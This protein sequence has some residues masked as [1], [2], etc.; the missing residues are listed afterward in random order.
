MTQ[1]FLHSVHVKERRVRGNAHFINQSKEENHENKP[2][3]EQQELQ[4]VMGTPMP[5]KPKRI[6]QKPS[7]YTYEAKEEDVK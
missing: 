4:Y 3:P 6:I 5:Q 1:F 2:E 7:K